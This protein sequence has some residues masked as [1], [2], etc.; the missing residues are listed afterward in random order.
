MSEP[1]KNTV[2]PGAFQALG[3]STQ[4]GLVP[5]GTTPPKRKRRVSASIAWRERPEIWYVLAGLAL[6]V[7]A[8]GGTTVWARAL[9]LICAGAWLWK[10]PPT[11]TPS[12]LFD[13][14]L[15]VL[16]AAALVSSFAPAAWFG[17]VGWRLDAHDL[18]VALPAT[19]APSPWL[20]AEA[21]AQLLAGAGWLYAWWNLRLDHENRKWALWGVAGLTTLLAI[22]LLVCSWLGWKYPLAE[23]ARNFSY[24]PNRNQ[25]ALWF[26]LGGVV[27]FGMLLESLPRRRRAAGTAAGV[28]MVICLMAL[29]L[30]L[31]RMALAL[32]A[33]GCVLVVVV[34]FGR[35]AG[36]Y[37]VRI[38][39][40]LA[41]LGM[42]LVVFLER[43]TIQRFQHSATAG[44][45]REFRVELWQDTLGMVKAQPAGAGLGQFEDV[46]PQYRERAQVYTAVYHP[47]SD[48]VWLL[49]ETGWAGVTA[50]AVAVGSLLVVFLGKPSRESGPYRHLAALCAALF[51][52][53]SLVDVP[54]HRFGTWLLAAWLLAL[55]APERAA[56]PTLFPRW[57][58]RALGLVLTAVGVAW[59]AAAA[60]LRV[61]TT[62]LQ[63]RT[64]S[65]AEAAIGNGNATAALAAADSLIAVRP[66]RWE[67]YYDRARAE[68]TIN[69]DQDAALQDFRRARFLEPTWAGLPYKE[70]ML[71]VNYDPALAYAAWREALQ[72]N[73]NVPDGTWH[74]IWGA[75]KDVPGGDD[76]LS[77]LSKTRPEYRYEYLMSVAP[78]RFA[79]EWQE[80]LAF[81]PLLA[82]YQDPVQ[83]QSLL[84]RWAELDG[85]A[86]LDYVG[87]NPRLAPQTW[88]VQMRALAQSGRY[89]DA[90]SLAQKR[91]PAAELPTAS[92]ALYDNDSD[93]VLAEMFQNNPQDLVV[94]AVL[95]KRQ[96]DAKDWS[97]AFETLDELNKL[98]LPPPF[99]SWWRAQ[100]LEQQGHSAEAWEALQPYLEYQRKILLEPSTGV[101]PPP[102]SVALPKPVPA[103]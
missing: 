103:K 8:G 7:L 62:V 61:Q 79:A 80:E 5:G 59:L 50:A 94:G 48:W 32:F 97:H 87:K 16:V 38:L 36:N 33:L 82:K 81:D 52:L 70:G 20:A 56:L 65:D 101:A 88:L 26:C 11:E 44:N 72:L 15:L 18:G 64:M 30:S 86:A 75:L 78:E 90:L 28:M 102:G 35:G 13:A 22:G 63:N 85:P 92:M 77:N 54:A 100:L 17:R 37:A 93:S 69:G 3:K 55:A 71:W 66:M 12:R 40:P 14:A 89:D 60:G 95:L 47:D 2:P 99:V 4:P 41:V 27:A 84:E 74:R 96:L 39:V 98:K 1:S 9:I 76:Y 68:L 67:P 23:E 58:F 25:T 29:I 51:F 49:G 57:V 45:E 6:T 19:N 31:S 43:D 53:H 21:L 91:L 34:R 10:R 73:D 83:R 42:S 46:Y 24:F